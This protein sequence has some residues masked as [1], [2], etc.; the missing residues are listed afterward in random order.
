MPVKESET[1]TPLRQGAKQG[2]NSGQA[3]AA[4]SPRP[5]TS[6]DSPRR[7]HHWRPRMFGTCKHQ[8]LAV[9]TTLDPVVTPARGDRR[10][11]RD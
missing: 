3:T 10:S 6:T 8:R 11:Y 9:L 7:S 4:P 5:L 2:A 1:I